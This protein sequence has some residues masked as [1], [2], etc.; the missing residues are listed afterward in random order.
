MKEL[1]GVMVWARQEIKHNY[2]GSFEA[3]LSKLL[4]TKPITKGNIL[5][6]QI[7]NIQTRRTF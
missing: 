5:S 6:M 1:Q 3:S 4:S 2:I 7:K